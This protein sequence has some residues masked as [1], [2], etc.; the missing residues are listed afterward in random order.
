M[1]IYNLKKIVYS[2]VFV[3]FIFFCNLS[4]KASELPVETVSGNEIEKNTLLSWHLINDKEAA[5]SY[6]NNEYVD[7]TNAPGWEIKDGYVAKK[8]SASKGDT[9]IFRYKAPYTAQDGTKHFGI[10][11]ID[12][13]D[14]TYSDIGC[15]LKVEITSDTSDNTHCYSL[16]DFSVNNQCPGVLT[17]SEWITPGN[18]AIV[19]NK[20][21]WTGYFSHCIRE[22]TDTYTL[23]K[24][25]SDGSKGEELS[26]NGS[27][28]S[29]SSLNSAYHVYGTEYG[30]ERTALIGALKAQLTK[31]TV[32]VPTNINGNPGFMGHGDFDDTVRSGTFLNGTVSY[33]SNSDKP[34]VVNYNLV[35]DFWHYPA[36]SPLYATI[37]NN[38]QK[39]IIKSQ[40]NEEKIGKDI[41]YDKEIIFAVKQKVENLGYT[42][43]AMYKQFSL[44][45]I[46]PKEYVEYK[47]ATMYYKDSSGN[48]CELDKKDYKIAEN[49]GVVTGEL[50]KDYL[51][52]DKMPYKME[53]YYLEIIA[54]PKVTDWDTGNN[55]VNKGYS[56]I[57]DKK[58][59]A[60]DLECEVAEPNVTIKKEVSKKEYKANEEIGYDI[61]VNQ[62]TDGALAHNVIVKDISLP[63]GLSIEDIDVISKDKIL[64]KTKTQISKEIKD[65][66]LTVIIPYLEKECDISFVCIDDEML[67][68][69]EIINTAHCS[70][71]WQDK[72]KDVYDDASIYVNVP[73]IK[74]D[75]TCSAKNIKKGEKVIYRIEVSNVKAGTIARN[76]VIEDSLKKEGLEFIKVLENTI[77]VYDE[78]GSDITNDAE[79]SFE[80]KDGSFLIKT[81]KNLLGID[82][83]RKIK[84]FTI[85]N[86]DK[87]DNEAYAD[88]PNPLNENGISHI[89]VEYQAEAIK[90]APN[91][92]ISNTAKATCDECGE[93]CKD[94]N[95][96]HIDTEVI[97]VKK[98]I[99]IDDNKETPTQIIKNENAKPYVEQKTSLP[100][101]GDSGIIWILLIVSAILGIITMKIYNR[102]K[103]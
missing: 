25:N 98:E 102:K 84:N 66:K 28:F 103:K 17:Y 72:Q 100:H 43:L 45:D 24:I 87:S 86:K 83:N 95:C 12:N 71:T 61:K 96:K 44:T 90:D 30:S 85:I 15:D 8:G 26:L 1:V 52:S 79:L 19:G 81:K 27:W 101:T 53:T 47:S 9:I 37:P 92:T 80:K 4:I 2:I 42:G 18:S 76:I 36:F 78:A 10:G 49:N 34:I 60:N 91:K 59:E 38:P 56:T 11:T 57:N 33:L 51:Q 7:I 31:D 41:K 97:D 48:K 94:N 3:L 74:V 65:N 75:K 70:Y 50:S 68:G 64:E 54:T 77:K 16:W 63:E 6:K 46:L 13:G 82:E 22:T 67:S 20:V 62:T 89:Y 14:G 88:K 35:N 39:V 55:F 93:E 21:F 58:F 99:S 40:N 32:L 5:I 29:T 69:K 23:Y 73:N